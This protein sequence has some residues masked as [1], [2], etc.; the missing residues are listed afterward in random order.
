MKNL[1]LILACDLNGVIGEGNKLPW[2]MPSDMKWFKENTLNKTVVMGRKTFESIGKPLPKRK[3]IILT[4]DINFKIDGAEVYNDLEKLLFEISI[5]DEET[6]V[7]GGGEIY[8]QLLPYCDSAFLTLINTRLES[9]DTRFQL[10]QLMGSKKWA[11]YIANKTQLLNAF[12][13]PTREQGFTK[14]DEKDQYQSAQMYF[15]RVEN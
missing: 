14:Y 8:K 1:S 15:R 3:N 12:G 10:N 9:G 7:I 11:Q 6:V 5:S 2:K 4:R 13:T